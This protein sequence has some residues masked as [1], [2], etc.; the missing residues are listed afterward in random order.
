[1]D[2]L[3]EANIIAILII[4]LSWSYDFYIQETL[5]FLV[6]D[7]NWQSDK[8]VQLYRLLI[9]K[10]GIPDLLNKA[11]GGNAIWNRWK[12]KGKIV[13]Y[14]KP[15]YILSGDIP[16]MLFA[17]FE[18]TEI[19]PLA[20]SEM[21]ADITRLCWPVVYDPYRKRLRIRATKWDDF[22]SR[23]VLAMRITTGEITASEIEKIVSTI[24][25]AGRSGSDKKES[26]NKLDEVECEDYIYQYFAEFSGSQT[27][28]VASK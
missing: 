4:L 12:D 5:E 21:I 27:T 13:V 24:V 16:I 2:S 9:Q 18:N 1:M 23:T 15:G 3:I 17:G 14:D 22:L 11:D 19:D 25:H 28:G 6:T 10:I 8:S 7:L 20:A 26:L